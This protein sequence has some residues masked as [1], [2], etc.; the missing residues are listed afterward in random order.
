MIQAQ[1]CSYS[2]N[3]MITSTSSNLRK[4]LCDVNCDPG[5]DLSAFLLIHSIVV[6]N[7]HTFGVHVHLTEQCTVLVCYNLSNSSVE[8]R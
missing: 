8:N 2:I 6:L 5:E 3:Q 7:L 1:A 4:L